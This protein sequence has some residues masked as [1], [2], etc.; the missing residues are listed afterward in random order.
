M[1][2]NLKGGGK[3]MENAKRR[4]GACWQ[5]PVYQLPFVYTYFVFSSCYGTVLRASF[6]LQRPP[7]NSHSMDCSLAAL[8]LNFFTALIPMP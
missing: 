2:A 6:S 1:G 7:L 5:M 3:R 4:F 8:P